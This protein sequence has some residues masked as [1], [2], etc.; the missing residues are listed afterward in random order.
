MSVANCPS[1]LRPALTLPSTSGYQIISKQNHESGNFPRVWVIIL[2]RRG[3]FPKILRSAC[4]AVCSKSDQG[5]NHASLRLVAV[6][7]ASFARSEEHTSELQSR[8]DL[9]CR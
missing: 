2:W 7:A 8:R 9:V 3:H 1:E 5:N 6:S 4:K